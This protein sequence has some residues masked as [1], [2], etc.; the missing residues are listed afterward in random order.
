MIVFIDDRPLRLIGPKAVDKLASLTDYDRIIDARLETLKAD[1]LHGH[2]LIL[3]ATPASAE[4]LIGLLEEADS[5]PL[6]SVTMQ[7]LDKD[8]V[9]TRIKSLY[10]VVKAGGGVVMSGGR[11]LLI[12]RRGVWDLPKGKLDDGESSKDGAVREV[13][14]ETGAVVSLGDKICTTYHTYTLNG[15]RILKRTKWY[16]MNL[17]DAT[18]L[19]P[20]AEENIEKVVFME[21][22]QAQ[23]ALASSFSSIRHVVEQALIAVK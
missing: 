22:K 10:K 16:R 2:L 21:P 5:R 19:A 12:F 13:E 7:C 1:A 17:V 14:E 23:I 9:E 20:Q 8:A 3:N 15:N 18:N 4:R 11:L 6:L